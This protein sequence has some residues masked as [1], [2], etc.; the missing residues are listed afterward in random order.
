MS[1]PTKAATARI[2]CR[3]WLGP[4]IPTKICSDGGGDRN[5]SSYSRM[6]IVTSRRSGKAEPFRNFGRIGQQKFRDNAP[7]MS[8]RTHRK[9]AVIGVT[10]PRSNDVC[11]T[12]HSTDG[13]QNPVLEAAAEPS[14]LLTGRSDPLPPHVTFSRDHKC[15]RSR[16]GPRGRDSKSP[17]RHSPRL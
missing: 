11:G 15:Q 5:R 14:H 6:V 1:P 13:K 10:L 4:R 3:L 12:L 16:G 8:V 9:N 7:L 2:R 17:A